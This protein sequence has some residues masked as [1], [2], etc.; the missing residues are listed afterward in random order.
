[1]LHYS[2]IPPILTTRVAWGLG[3]SP[4]RVEL[5]AL[6]GLPPAAFV[7]IPPD[8]AEKQNGAY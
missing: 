5:E 8:I 2:Q 1:M 4:E 6:N 7:T 3:R